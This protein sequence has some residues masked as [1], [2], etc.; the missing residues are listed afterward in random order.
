M[1]PNSCSLLQIYERFSKFCQVP[2]TCDNRVQEQDVTEEEEDEIPDSHSQPLIMAF[3]LLVSRLAKKY[4]MENIIQRLVVIV[5][6]M[7][8][9]IEIKAKYDYYSYLALFNNMCSTLAELQK[10]PEACRSLQRVHELILEEYGDEHPNTANS[11]FSIGQIH[12][13]KHLT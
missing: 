9:E 6:D 7:V 1:L 12:F 5:S 4:H 13:S 2:R 8:N 11:Y 10:Q 3:T